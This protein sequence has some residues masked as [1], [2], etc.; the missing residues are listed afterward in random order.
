MIEWFTDPLMIR[1]ILGGI[2]IALIAGPL[3]CFVV[4][5][6][7]AYLGD[8]IAHSSLLGIALGAALGIG[9]NAGSFIVGLGFAVL[10]V[11]L[12]RTHIFAADTMLGILA[13]A[14]LSLGLIIM[15]LMP[16]LR[17]NLFHYLFGDVLAIGT[18]D[19]L[20]IY[21]GA[22]GIGIMFIYLWQSLLLTTLHED[23]AKA[24]GIATERIHFMMML[25]LTLVIAIA[26]RIVGAL[27]ITSLLIIPA[28]TARRF[29]CS[30]MQMVLL[31]MLCGMIAV[32]L[33][34]IESVFWNLPAGPAISATSVG[35]FA[36]SFLLPIPHKN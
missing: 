23:L 28:A 35:L 15:S 32:L 1:A 12:R 8:A 22:I 9:M 21:G 14:A 17:P 7:M 24:E 33:G 25:I 19:L 13:H 30:P 27:L 5:R 16:T 10:I 34:L 29:A 36:V 3:G 20:W 26:L 6:R 18:L 11:V 4:W 31:S 2:G